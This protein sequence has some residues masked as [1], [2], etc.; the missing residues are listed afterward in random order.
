MIDK[1]TQPTLGCGAK[2]HNSKKTLKV[3][4]NICSFA[5]CGAKIHS[6]QE[7]EQG[8]ID[9]VEDGNDKD[10]CDNSDT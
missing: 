5:G 3:N 7:E 9:D 6:G 1:M 10:D 8:G 4:T 2:I